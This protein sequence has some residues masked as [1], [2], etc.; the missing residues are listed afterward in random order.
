[1]V[2]MQIFFSHSTAIVL[3]LDGSYDLNTSWKK[4]NNKIHTLIKL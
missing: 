2:I 4:R 3:Y 1:M